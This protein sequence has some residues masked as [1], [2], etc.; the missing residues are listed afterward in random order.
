MLEGLGK[1]FINPNNYNKLSP[2]T[3][4]HPLFLG[5]R[6]QPEQARPRAGRES[7]NGESLVGR[8]GQHFHLVHPHIVQALVISA[9]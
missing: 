4:H 1:I 6:T 9:T 7:G 2:P 5:T 8:G 3:W